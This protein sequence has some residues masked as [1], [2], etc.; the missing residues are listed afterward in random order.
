ME[1]TLHV[2]DIKIQAFVR[3][4]I[5]KILRWYSDNSW[6]SACLSLIFFKK[7]HPLV[8]FKQLYETGI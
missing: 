4:R 1:D 8:S 5:Q 2:T 6:H 3:Q 7:L